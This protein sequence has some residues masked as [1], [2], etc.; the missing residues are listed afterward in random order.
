[1]SRDSSTHLYGR[2]SEAMVDSIEGGRTQRRSQDQP[3]T[4]TGTGTATTTTEKR[5]EL[6]FFARTV[7]TTST[8][9]PGYGG[10]KDPDPQGG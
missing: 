5:F 10:E 6:G 1:M 7:T 4:D 9:P 8:T 3:A 2:R